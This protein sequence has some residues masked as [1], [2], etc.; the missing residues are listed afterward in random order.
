MGERQG[1]DHM[2]KVQRTGDKE[3]RGETGKRGRET[4]STDERQGT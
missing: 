3:Q 1:T 2:R 4:R